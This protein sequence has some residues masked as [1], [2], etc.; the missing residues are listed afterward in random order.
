MTPLSPS[1]PLAISFQLFVRGSRFQPVP[2]P[3]LIFLFLLVFSGAF[4]ASV[5]AQ[6]QKEPEL[7][8]VHGSVIDRNQNPVPSSVVYLKNMKT[9]GVRTYIADDAGD[10][11]FSGLDPNVDYEIHAEHNDLESATR[12]I[13]S[14][15]SRRDINLPLKLSHKK[16]GQ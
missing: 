14:Y 7:R 4:G 1:R 11:R 12:T 16:T 10:Y 13:S 15:D 5:H 8:T 2:G 9:Q 3:S 6:D